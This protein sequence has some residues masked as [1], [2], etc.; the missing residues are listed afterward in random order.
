MQRQAFTLLELLLVVLIMG[1]VYGLAVNAI[2]QYGERSYALSLETLP[3]YLQSFHRQNR[4]TLLCTDACQDCRVMVDGSEVKR[5]D[6]FIDGPLRAYRF[7]AALGTRDLSFTPYFDEE[8]REFEVCLRFE[9]FPN[10][11]SSEM[12]IEQEE[13]V[14]DFPGYF[15]TPTRFATLEEAIEHKRSVIKKATE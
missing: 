13:Y 7:D 10:G 14:V 8:E 4:V 1:I 5:V 6:P 11:S 3:Q 15:G 2:K 12:I 9:V